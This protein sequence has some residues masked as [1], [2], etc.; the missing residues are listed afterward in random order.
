MKYKI[1]GRDNCPF[2]VKAETLLKMIQSEYEYVD[3]WGED[4]E[5]LQKL[6]QEKGWKTVPQIYHGDNYVG[7]F[8][9]LNQY[10]K[11]L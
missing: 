11:N 9:E 10:L 2:C 4:K 3:V 7:G 6:F 8:T 5:A 1:Y